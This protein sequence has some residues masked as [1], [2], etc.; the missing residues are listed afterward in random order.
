MIEGYAMSGRV[1]FTR[2]AT[3]LWPVAWQGWALAIVPAVVAVFLMVAIVVSGA[4]DDTL[5]EIGFLA[6]VIATALAV[7]AIALEKS[8]RRGATQMKRTDKA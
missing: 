5:V 6:A 2:G 3:F 1:W 4:A 8:V 7:Y